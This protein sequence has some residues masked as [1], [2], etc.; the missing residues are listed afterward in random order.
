MITDYDIRVLPKV[1][2]KEEY[3]KDFLSKEK[4][5]CKSDIRAVQILRRSIDARS[6]TVF[7]QLKVRVF[8]N[9]NPAPPTLINT[10][11]HDVS[12][13]KQ[14]VVVG[15]GPAGLFAS[16]QLL[17]SG[18]KPILIERGSRTSK[19]KTDIAKISTTGIV[20]ANS[21]YCFGEGGAGTFS[22]G[23]LYTRSNKRGNIDKILN[24]FVEFEF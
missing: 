22:D 2:S 8:V 18:I 6:R 11:Y 10:N 16:L 1:A 17:E 15:A 19:R 21:N 14:A 23:K 3:L 20:D 9:E 24:I 12:K 13:C 7:M 4:G 5:L